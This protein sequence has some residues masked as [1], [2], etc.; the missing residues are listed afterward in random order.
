[1]VFVNFLR[2]SPFLLLLVSFMTK[3]KFMHKITDRRIKTTKWSASNYIENK[4]RN[5]ES[6]IKTEETN[7]ENNKNRKFVWNRT[8]KKW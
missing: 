6:K 2:I 1:M 4:T 8:N 3:T 7:R 5:N